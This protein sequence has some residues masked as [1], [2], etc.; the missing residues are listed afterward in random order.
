MVAVVADMTPEQQEMSARLQGTNISPQT[1]LATDYL[2]HFNEV[3]MLIDMLAD[4]PDMFEEVE[5]WQPKTYADHFRDSVFS[6][7]D[8]AIT[9]Y[10]MAPARYREPFDAT[11]AQANDVVLTSISGLRTALDAENMEEA[12]FIAQK[13]SRLL[14]KLIDVA[15]A[16]I[17]GSQSGMSQSEV[18]AYLGKS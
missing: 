4:M 14:Q 8:L 5:E 15:S 3:I 9:A 11:I 2:N 16:I 7:K 13:A 17:H 18:D 6:D 12:A 10:E 1:F